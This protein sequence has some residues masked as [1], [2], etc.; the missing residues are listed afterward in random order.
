MFEFIVWSFDN[1]IF[2]TTA[3]EYITKIPC[4]QVYWYRCMVRI[5]VPYC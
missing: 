4:C 3:Q 1:E 2:G 5:V